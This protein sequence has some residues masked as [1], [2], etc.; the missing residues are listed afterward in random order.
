MNVIIIVAVVVVVVSCGRNII[1][2]LEW[3]LFICTIQ[4]HEVHKP[5]A[6]FDISTTFENVISKWRSSSHTNKSYTETLFFPASWKDSGQTWM[7]FGDVVGVSCTFASLTWS[8]FFFV[9][10][11][12][13]LLFVSHCF[14]W[15]FLIRLLNVIIVFLFLCFS[16]ILCE[17]FQHWNRI[18]EAVFRRIVIKCVWNGENWYGLWSQ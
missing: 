18:V 2:Y 17:W 6:F 10:F 9:L 16:Y 3:N 1:Y 11:S 7:L 13:I 8:F 5:V 14:V 4:H 15:F 12:T